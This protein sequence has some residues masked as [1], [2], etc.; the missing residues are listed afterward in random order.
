VAD[1]KN[2]TKPIPVELLLSSIGQQVRVDIEAHRQRLLTDLEDR[3]QKLAELRRRRQELLDRV[4]AAVEEPEA[5]PE[6]APGTGFFEVAAPLTDDDGDDWLASEPE[7]DAAGYTG[8]DGACGSLLDD[9]DD[10]AEPE[11]SP[12]WSAK[13]IPGADDDGDEP[14]EGPELLLTDDDAISFLADADGDL[15]EPEAAPLPQSSVWDNPPARSDSPAI[16]P[17]PDLPSLDDL[18][19]KASDLLNI[20]LEV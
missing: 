5:V 9:N 12:T 11:A 6:M 16:A 1:P 13:V 4:P 7:A 20:D 8:W 10:L 3:R 19:G 2:S 14:D 15:V 17:S 18:F